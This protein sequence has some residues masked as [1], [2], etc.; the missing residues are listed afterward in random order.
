MTRNVWKLVIFALLLL[1]LSIWI[2]TIGTD[3]KF[4]LIQCAVGEGDATLIVYK[5]SQILIDGGPNTSVLSCLEKYMPMGD[6]KIELV[7]L[8]HP[9]ADHYSGLIDVANSFDV[10]VL[11]KND[12]EISSQK[13][14]VLINALGGRGIRVVDSTKVRGIRLGMIYIDILIDEEVREKRNTEKLNMFSIISLIRFKGFEALL[15]GDYEFNSRDSITLK[16]SGIVPKEGV[17]YIKIPH[18]GSKNGLTRKLLEISKPKL[19]GISVGNNRWGHPDENI[20]A[21][22]QEFKV[23]YLRTDQIGDLEIVSD[24]KGF[25]IR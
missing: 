2:L 14:S 15:T 21:I 5:R 9:E 11:V 12:L 10:D 13:Y 8:T 24:G 1:T 20:T 6:R 16:I 22:L 17:D 23:K 7:I 4:H 18:H 19:A 3:D 25:A